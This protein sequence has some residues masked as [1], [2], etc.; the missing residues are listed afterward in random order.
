MIH[1]LKA[2]HIQLTNKVIITTLGKVIGVQ[3][4]HNKVNTIHIIIQ[5]Q[6]AL[7][8]TTTIRN[9]VKTISHKLKHIT[10][11]MVAD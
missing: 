10:Q 7:K 11:T 6:Q 3:T 5:T 1:I 4:K 8:T 2:I 9:I